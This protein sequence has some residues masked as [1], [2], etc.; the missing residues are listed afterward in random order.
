MNKLIWLHKTRQL[1]VTMNPVGIPAVGQTAQFASSVKNYV[2][3]GVHWDNS[4]NVG[5]TIVV[6]LELQE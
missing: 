3:T 6:Q 5:A 4:A 2:V 1:C